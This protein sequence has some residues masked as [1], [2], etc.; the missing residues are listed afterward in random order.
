MYEEI[1]VRKLMKKSI[2][3]INFPFFS[4]VNVMKKRYDFLEMIN[5]QEVMKAGQRF[6]NTLNE[7]SVYM[8]EKVYNPDI[9]FED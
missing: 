7:I 3:I 1:Y 9:E 8:K 5:G 4:F 6:C 2:F